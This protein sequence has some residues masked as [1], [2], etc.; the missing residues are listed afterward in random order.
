MSDS[1]QQYILSK[2]VKA[3]LVEWPTPAGCKPGDYSKWHIDVSHATNIST[4]YRTL[5]R[6]SFEALFQPLDI[7]AIQK[8]LEEIIIDVV[9]D[10]G[11]E[12]HEFADAPNLYGGGDKLHE[13]LNRIRQE[14]VSEILVLFGLENKE[15]N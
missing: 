14:A 7:P 6:E 5:D 4:D 10:C 2:P 8:Q 9:G 15:T 1:T 11:Y 3:E 13:N 12:K